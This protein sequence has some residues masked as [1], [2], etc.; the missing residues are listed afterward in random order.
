[1]G[2]STHCCVTLRVGEGGAWAGVVHTSGWRGVGVLS[3]DGVGVL[4]RDDGVEVGSAA[5]MP[6]CASALFTDSTWLLISVLT[7][8]VPHPIAPPPALLWRRCRW[9]A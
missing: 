3:R 1:M 7:V 8:L 4:S 9:I 5:V 6:V 2:L